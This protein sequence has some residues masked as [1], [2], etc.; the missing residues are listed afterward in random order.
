MKYGSF[1]WPPVVAV[2]PIAK[3]VTLTELTYSLTNTAILSPK[4]KDCT[5]INDQIVNTLIEDDS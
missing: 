1:S 3:L 5:K 4:N 2:L